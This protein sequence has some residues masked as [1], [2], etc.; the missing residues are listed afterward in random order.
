MKTVRPGQG[1]IAD[2]FGRVIR[3]QRSP[4]MQA[5]AALVIATAAAWPASINAQA[6]M[7]ADL[8][9]AE[10]EKGFW[11][12]DHMATTRGLDGVAAMTCSQLTEAL[13]QR[14]FD[15]DFNA[16]LAWWRQLKPAEHLALAQAGEQP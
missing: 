11:I 16:M 4:V 5:T 12:C 10:L 15:G 6:A 13:K 7:G 2:R 9:M 3:G 8:P 14:K 1:P